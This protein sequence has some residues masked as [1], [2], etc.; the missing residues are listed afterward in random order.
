MPLAQGEGP[1]DW[2]RPPVRRSRRIEQTRRAR[3]E[4]LGEVGQGPL[5]KRSRPKRNCCLIGSRV[6]MR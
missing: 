5:L 4:T 2:R 6:Q 3:M 1:Q